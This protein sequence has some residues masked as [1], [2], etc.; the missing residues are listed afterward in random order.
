MMRGIGESRSTL[1]EQA[2]GSF[3]DV[4]AAVAPDGH[5]LLTRFRS[6][7]EPPDVV[8]TEIGVLLCVL[9]GA[10]IVSVAAEANLKVCVAWPHWEV[11]I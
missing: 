8:G 11:E 2:D 6:S 4:I 7:D 5:H 10:F 9:A 3:E 1:A